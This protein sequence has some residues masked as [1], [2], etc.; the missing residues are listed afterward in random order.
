MYNIYSIGDGNFLYTVF[1]AISL[2]CYGES[3]SSFSS[4]LMRIYSI[5][6]LLGFLWL[7]V[8]NIMTQK[9]LNLGSYILAWIIFTGLFVPKAEVSITD[10]QTQQVRQLDNVPLIVGV[11][12]NIISSV[13]K[14]ITN[15][16]ENFFYNV[17]GLSSGDASLKNGGGYLGYLSLIMNARRKLEAETLWSDIDARLCNNLSYC[18]VNSKQSFQNYMTD[19]GAYLTRGLANVKESTITSFE[20]FK[21]T[22]PN[23]HTVI[24]IDPNVINGTYVCSVAWSKLNGVLQQADVKNVFMSYLTDNYK[25]EGEEKSDTTT[26]A[27]TNEKN[28]NNAIKFLTGGNGSSTAYDYVAMTAL[29]PL[30]N[31]GIVRFE[32]WGSESAR[33]AIM[34]KQAQQQR[35]IQWGAEQSMFENVMR[36]A[37]TFFEGFVYAITPLMPFF[38][39]F[40]MGGL[41][42]I[43]KYF[44]LIMWVQLWQPCLAIC[45]FYIETTVAQKLSGDLINTALSS[46]AGMDTALEEIQHWVAI[47][48]LLAASIPFLSLFIL[49]GSVYTF[50]S[51]AG[52]MVGGDFVNEKAVSPD[53]VQHAPMINNSVGAVESNASGSGYAVGSTPNYMTMN[54]GSM[55]SSAKS[56]ANNAVRSSAI[57]VGKTLS[58]AYNSI[59]NTS[60]QQAFMESV[61]NNLQTQNSKQF[62]DAYQFAKNY[63][64]SK[65]WSFSNAETNAFA[66]ALMINQATSGSISIGGM[67]KGFGINGSMARSN[68]DNK[69]N[70]NQN[71]NTDLN[72]ASQNYN[73]QVSKSK[74]VS[75]GSSI[76]SALGKATQATNQNGVNYGYSSEKGASISRSSQEAISTAKSYSELNAMSSSMATSKSISS[77]KAADYISDKTYDDYMNPYRIDSE[78]TLSSEDRAKIENRADYIDGGSIHGK[79]AALWEHFAEK[80]KSGDT[81]AFKMLNG[82][83]NNE[84]GVNAEST[85]QAHSGL[86]TQSSSIDNEFNLRKNNVLNNQGG[87]IGEV[88]NNTSSLTNSVN[89]GQNEVQE[90]LTQNESKTKAT[91]NDVTERVWGNVEDSYDNHVDNATSAGKTYE[92]ANLD[93]YTKRA[94]GVARTWGYELDIHDKNDKVIID[95]L[96]YNVCPSI[97][98]AR[99]EDI[100]MADQYQMTNQNYQGHQRIDFK[101]R[102]MDYKPT[103]DEL[104]IYVKR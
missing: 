2:M 38:L 54:L 35:D 45:N 86:K 99:G 23:L 7:L 34:L 89:N 100:E 102:K 93:P 80:V 46:Y 11:S 1:N 24:N 56:S 84:Y 41:N 79:K 78:L 62:Q 22:N 83:F 73:D 85:A 88:S 53:V 28:L 90:T 27:L 67:F 9:P 103:V 104:P 48:G 47:G 3:G 97:L 36:P 64:D 25:M 59:T 15:Q 26:R 5:S 13:G 55:V 75:D 66:S 87:I 4:G 94:L 65:G 92:N 37:I 96:R 32:S 71:F 12:G 16:F 74:A 39:F 43:G 60:Q 44:M 76:A 10:L 14:A 52:R 57:N 72:Q 6:A 58:D 50:N 18:T 8:Q 31:E 42:L 33:A 19:C 95:K 17:G 82:N 21:Y 101:G 63:A 61:A 68:S 29:R 69:S 70:T 20:K 30:Y 81:T 40:G 77:N 98:S 51:I 49:T 91:G